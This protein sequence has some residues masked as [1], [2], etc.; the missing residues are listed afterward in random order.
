M[1]SPPPSPASRALR[2]MVAL[3]YFLTAFG[4]LLALLPWGWGFVTAGTGVLSFLLARTALQGNPSRAGTLAQKI[5]GVPVIVYAVCMIVVIPTRTTTHT[6]QARVV[7]TGELADSPSSDPDKEVDEPSQGVVLEVEP[8]TA[9]LA[10]RTT[11]VR[12]VYLDEDIPSPTTQSC[13][14]SLQIGAKVEVAVEITRRWLS[15]EAKSYSV[16]RIGDC[17]LAGHD[18]TAVLKS[19]F[20]EAWLP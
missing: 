16:S 9:Q 13:L 8:C 3:S 18:A 17:T 1:T 11:S 10:V 20:C 6:A 14:A 15:S 19:G 5:S 2:L 7:A 4:L 12:D